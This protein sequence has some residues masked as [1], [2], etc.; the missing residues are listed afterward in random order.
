MP[1]DFTDF[2]LT[3]TIRK[4]EGR[5]NDEDTAEQLEDDIVPSAGE[6]MSAGERQKLRVPFHSE[7]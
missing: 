3:K 5:V 4:I 1:A 2:S 7:L 6:E